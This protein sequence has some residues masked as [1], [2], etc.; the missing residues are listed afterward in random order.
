MSQEILTRF[1]IRQ[2][3]CG[4]AWEF[5]AIHMVNGKKEEKAMAKVVS[6]NSLF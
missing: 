1:F 6:R 3:L 2:T 4:L 5:S